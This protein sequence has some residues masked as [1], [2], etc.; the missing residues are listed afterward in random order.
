MKKI[1]S[2]LLVPTLLVGCTSP[3]NTEDVKAES[4]VAVKAE[5]KQPQGKSGSDELDPET[6]K[7]IQKIAKEK[8]DAIR[9]LGL[10]IE[11]FKKKLDDAGA[12]LEWTVSNPGTILETAHAKDEVANVNFQFFGPENDLKRLSISGYITDDQ[13]KSNMVVAYLQFFLKEVLPTYSPQDIV[14]LFEDSMNKLAEQKQES[15]PRVVY[16]IDGKRLTI[17]KIHNMIGIEVESDKKV[18]EKK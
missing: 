7:S 14:N 11:Q 3:K 5:E 17:L 18:L 4:S 2:L 13:I 10:T 16:E 6:I 8:Y 1:I 15:E 9:G 12:R